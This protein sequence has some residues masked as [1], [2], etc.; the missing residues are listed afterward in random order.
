M[1]YTTQLRELAG[2][3]GISTSYRGW[4]DAEYEVSDTTLRRIFRAR[5]ID[6]NTEAE[7]AAA[8]ADVDDAPWRRML[9]ECYKRLD[10]S[11][12]Q[13]LRSAAGPCRTML[14][15]WIRIEALTPDE[16]I[17]SAQG[18]NRTAEVTGSNPLSSTL[19]SGSEE[20][21]R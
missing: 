10:A 7:V 2:K 21:A 12:P 18:D 13:F 6:A 4:D 1:D 17:K 20:A 19:E 5:G 14:R 15:F 3:C 11:L 8:T 9:P 16:L